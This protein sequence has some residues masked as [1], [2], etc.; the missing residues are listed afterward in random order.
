MDL[1]YAAA[2]ELFE[3]EVIGFGTYKDFVEGLDA[4]ETG[5]W[6]SIWPSIEGFEFELSSLRTVMAEDRK[7]ATAMLT[8]TST[9]IA[10]GGSRYARPGRATVVLRRRAID[11]DWRGAHTHFS[12]FPGERK[13]SFGVGD[14]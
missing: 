7:S 10:E 1:D 6:R 13:L 2:R 4:L 5:Q 3:A 12:L 9:G 11:A 8:W 14:R